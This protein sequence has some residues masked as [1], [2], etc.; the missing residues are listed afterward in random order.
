MLSIS[1]LRLLPFGSV[2]ARSLC[3][4]LHWGFEALPLESSALKQTRGVLS[5]RVPLELRCTVKGQTSKARA[6]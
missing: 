6:R 5:I 3:N 1:I 2:N 4:L